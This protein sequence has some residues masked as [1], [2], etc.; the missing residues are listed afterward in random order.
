MLMIINFFI[1]SMVIGGP[2]SGVGNQ[3]LWGAKCLTLGEQQHFCFGS[4][5]K[6]QN[7]QIR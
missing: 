5:F 3:K 1:V 7:D 6:A 2:A 4:R